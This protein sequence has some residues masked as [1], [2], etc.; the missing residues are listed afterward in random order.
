[1]DFKATFIAFS[2]DKQISSRET[3]LQG[4]YDDENPEIDDS[5]FIKANK[6]TAVEIHVHDNGNYILHKNY[7]NEDGY[8]Y[9]FET[10]EN[11]VTTVEKV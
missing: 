5:E 9:R 4:Y 11:G 3:D 7:Y 6:I 2:G 10:T 8:P 1:M